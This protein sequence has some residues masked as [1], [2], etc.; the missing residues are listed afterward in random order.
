MRLCQNSATPKGRLKPPFLTCKLPQALLGFHTVASCLLPSAY[1][2]LSTGSPAFFHA[3][4]PPS[5]AAAF[6]IPFFLRSSTAPALVCSFGQEQYVTIVL[7]RGNSFERSAI[8]V[9]GIS[10]APRT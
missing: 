3:S 6:S 2:P 7:S 8:W 4:M 10:F 1:C 9:L 5:K